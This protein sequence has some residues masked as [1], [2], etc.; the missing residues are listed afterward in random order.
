MMNNDMN[1][2]DIADV[3]LEEIL[4]MDE[5]EVDT[6]FEE[7]NLSKE[8]EAHKL[9]EAF[10]NS[11][12]LVAKKEKLKL[13]R[14]ELDKQQL[15]LKTALEKELSDM[16]GILTNMMVKGLLP[17]ELTMAFR[18]GTHITDEELLGIYED[19]QELGIDLDD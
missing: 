9:N 4:E 17:Q 16:R 10:R 8:H 19:L 3:L 13:S 5:S 14:L 11:E 12:A 6:I 1:K 2:L 18:D 7:M 15:P